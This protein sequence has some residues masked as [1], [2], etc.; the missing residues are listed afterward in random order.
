MLKMSTARNTRMMMSTTAIHENARRKLTTGELTQVKLGNEEISM[1]Y[2]AGIAISS[3]RKLRLTRMSMKMTNMKEKSV[4]SASS[5]MRLRNL[6]KLL[7]KS[8][9]VDVWLCFGSKFE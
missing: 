7:A 8:R 1:R 2:V 3:L 9:T 5:E 4:R 6:D